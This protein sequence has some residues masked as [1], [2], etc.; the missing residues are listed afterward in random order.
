MRRLSLLIV[1]LIMGL[2]IAAQTL[3]VGSYNIRYKNK[4]D[5]IKG[6][7]WAVRFPSICNQILWE[8][9]DVFGAQEVLHSQ[10]LDLN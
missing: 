4:E 8:Q 6:N 10:L 9:P 3:K 1:G 7:S 5:S 2:G